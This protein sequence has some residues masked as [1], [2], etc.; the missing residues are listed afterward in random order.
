[1]DAKTLTLNIAVDMGR[2][3]RWLAQGNKSRVEQ[4]IKETEDYIDLLEKAS[5]ANKQSFSSNKFKKTFNQFKKSFKNIKSNKSENLSE[6]A[7]TWAN[8]LTHRSNLL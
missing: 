4:F 1:M 8:I 7:Y 3:G 6:E 2:I 5:K